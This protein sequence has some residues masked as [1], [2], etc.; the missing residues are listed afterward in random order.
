MIRSK[1]RST[2]RNHAS[3]RSAFRVA[4]ISAAVMS[5]FAIPNAAFAFDIDTG[6]PDLALRWDNTVRYNIG[7]RVVDQDKAMLGNVNL[8]DGDRNFKKNSLVANRIDILSEID[9]VWQR[10]FGGRVSLAGWYDFAYRNLDNTSPQTSNTLSNGLP[11][12]GLSG[13]TERY[14]KGASGE[15]LDAFG[16]ANFD[17]GAIPINIKAGQHSVFWGD[18]ILGNG[19][20][21]S[22]A[23]GQLP[24]DQ[25]KAVATPGSEAKEIFRPRQGI[26]LQAQPLNELSIAGQWFWDW[27][28]WRYAESGSYLTFN[29]A[30]QHGADS[31][32]TGANALAGVFPGSPVLARAW[33]VA[34][35]NPKNNTD[36]GISARWSPDWLDG[37]LGFY[38]RRSADMQ[39]QL[40]VTPG[41]APLSATFTPAVCTA[42]GGSPF[43]TAAGPLC[44]LPGGS[45]NAADLSQKGRIG[46]YN[47]AYG[48]GMNIYGVSFAKNIGGISIG[49]EI[50]YREGMPLLSD[51]VNV[52]PYPIANFAGGN[53]A[54]SCPP[55]PALPNCVAVPTNNTP[56]AK[57]NTWHGLVNAVGVLPKTALFD[58]LSYTAELTWMMWDKVTQNEAV[59]KGRNTGPINPATGL[60][61]W[62]A[63]TAIDRVSKSYF[64]LAVNLTPTWFQ[65]YPGVDLLMPLTW[66][67]GMAGNSAVAGGGQD[68]TGTFSVGL[69]AD[70]YNK[71]RVDLKYVG[72]FGNY[73]T[74]PT[75]AVT[76]ANGTL[77]GLIDRGFVNLTFKTTF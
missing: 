35:V 68:G 32:I 13:Y 40:V 11:V 74:G 29:D 53:V 5:A 57:G 46:S 48:T 6:N 25:W 8:D 21:H 52:L 59:F 22:V 41:V 42:I 1:A 9:L 61:S 39:P 38:Y 4:A 72:F 26:T 31:L 70:I 66:Q 62:A 20:V 77:A 54:T 27:Q 51:P 75:G 64:G 17:I 76:V 14:A 71:Y 60:P 12:V 18:S 67:Q 37:T 24:L 23:Y 47:L 58:T 36:W 56:G 44:V 34:D 43:P 50:S 7:M 63:Y 55:A 3:R 19:A 30:V 16:F 28:S 65:V 69:A 49:S 73:S 33:H 10:S 2:V 45:T 15:V